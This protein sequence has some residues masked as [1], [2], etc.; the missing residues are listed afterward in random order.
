MHHPRS[1]PFGKPL[2]WYL[3]NMV[4]ETKCRVHPDRKGNI[5]VCGLGTELCQ[6]CFDK[7]KREYPNSS[8]DDYRNI[9][10]GWI[11]TQTSIVCPGCAH[12]MAI[13]EDAQRE[14][15]EFLKNCTAD[16]TVR[17]GFE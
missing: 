4:N 15:D 7:F 2:R 9:V 3:I 17:M 12:E 10:L 1:R 6:S 13:L 16:E 5:W 11:Q 8:G 14:L